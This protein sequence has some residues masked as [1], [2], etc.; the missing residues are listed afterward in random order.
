VRGFLR[1]ATQ[2]EQ[3]MA[4]K[5]VSH[6]RLSNRCLIVSRRTRIALARNGNE[7][8]RGIIGRAAGMKLSYVGN[9]RNN[10]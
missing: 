10:K 9:F 4:A 7:P 8:R 3:D 2:F 5:K 6:K 1:L